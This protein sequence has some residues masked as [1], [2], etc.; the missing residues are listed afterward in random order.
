M[1]GYDPK[2]G[3]PVL[4]DWMERV[5]KELNPYYDEAHVFVNKIAAGGEK[6]KL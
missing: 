3:R 4:A 1:A 2:D 5:K 6:A